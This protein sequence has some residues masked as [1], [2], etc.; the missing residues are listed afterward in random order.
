[1]A[2][3]GRHPPRV[4]DPRSRAH[5]RRP[6]LDAFSGFFLTRSTTVIYG[7]RTQTHGVN[8]YLSFDKY[9]RFS[10]TVAGNAFAAARDRIDQNRRR[11]RRRRE[12]RTRKTTAPP[13]R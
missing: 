6:R 1:M 12:R 11:R 7:A 10:F 4:A 2:R 9:R 13:D 3:R 8:D 5:G